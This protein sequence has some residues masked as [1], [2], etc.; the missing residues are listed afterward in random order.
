MTHIHIKVLETLEI[1]HPYQNNFPRVEKSSQMT[2]RTAHHPILRNQN[3]LSYFPNTGHLDTFTCQHNVL[4]V[5][6]IYLYFRGKKI[7]TNSQKNYH[8]RKGKNL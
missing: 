6:K 2:K 1:L 4:F 8:I 3:L 7:T 5:F